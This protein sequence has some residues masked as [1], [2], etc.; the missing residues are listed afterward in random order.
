MSMPNSA[1]QQRGRQRLFKRDS[2]GQKGLVSPHEIIQH[3]RCRRVIDAGPRYYSTPAFEYM[4]LVEHGI[5]FP[6]SAMVSSRRSVPRVIDEFTFPV[7]VKGSRSRQGRGV[8]LLEDVKAVRKLVDQ[9]KKVYPAMVIREFIPNDGDIRVLTVGYKSVGAMKRTPPEGDF[10]ANISQ[11]GSGE[12][13]DLESH[14]EVQ[15]MAEV[16]SEVLGIEVAGVDVMIHQESGERYL[17][18]VNSGPQIAGIERYTGLNAAKE[19][20]LYFESLGP[21]KPPASV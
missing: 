19:I 8:R 6:K 7:V 5:R 4:Q 16:A 11:G 13:F 17:L 15:R 20:V 10:R 1:H 14:P 3:V 21:R 12:S 9:K 18:E 2:I